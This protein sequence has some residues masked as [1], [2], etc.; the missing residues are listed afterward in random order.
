MR[1]ALGNSLVPLQSGEKPTSLTLCTG[2]L[3][4]NVEPA[5]LVWQVGNANTIGEGRSHYARDNKEGENDE[6]AKDATDVFD[7]FQS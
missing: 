5:Y 3:Y 7:K 1:P 6:E 2:T 4:E